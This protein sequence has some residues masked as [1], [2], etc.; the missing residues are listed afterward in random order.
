MKTKIHT[1]I[2]LVIILIF[3]SLIVPNALAADGWI[4][5]DENLANTEN[6]SPTLFVSEPNYP[7]V[8]SY[9]ISAYYSPLPGQ[10]KYSTGSYE[11]EIR[12]NGSGVNGADGTPVYPGMIAAPSTY[13][14]G[15]KMHIPGFGVGTV[16]DRGG[17]I[18]KAGE[19]G[20]AHDRLDIWMGYGDKGLERALNW[21][22]RTVEVTV[23]GVDDSIVENFS[24]PDYSDNEKFIIADSF[25]TA[26][27]TISL[28]P[29]KQYPSIQTIEPGENGDH[30]KE[31]QK[32]LS[33]LGYYTGEINGLYD[34]ITQD[35][36]IDFQVTEK[37]VDNEK[38]Y[39][40]GYVGPRT[41]SVLANAETANIA[42]AA[43]KQSIQLDDTFKTDLY[44]GMQSDDV[45]LLQNELTKMNLYKADLNGSYDELTEHAVFKFQQNFNI[46]GKKSD[47]GAGVF[48]PKTR[49][50][51]NSI[52]ASR[53]YTEKMKKDKIL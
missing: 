40:A 34:K 35:A 29:K 27:D 26:T 20:Y 13:G 48:G 50:K 17:A 7:Y 43:E 36:V 49:S 4:F 42:H 10:K 37:V 38:A 25:N 41:I 44:S 21:G 5:E 47:F 2:L 3:S 12:L 52:I 18:V 32:L 45:T 14:F 11:S 28:A 15:T 51:M 24:I 19:R 30:V 23:Y 22:K 33:S 6:G 8:Q 39:G 31:V 53:D 16:H 1:L 9:V 46:I